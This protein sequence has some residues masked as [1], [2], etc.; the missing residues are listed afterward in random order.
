MECER[1][2][3]RWVEQLLEPGIAEDKLIEA[4]G[5]DQPVHNRDPLPTLIEPSPIHSHYYNTL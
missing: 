2:A 3:L 5:H 4:V 1:R